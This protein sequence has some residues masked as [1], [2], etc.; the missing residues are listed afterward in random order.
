M[1]PTTTKLLSGN[2]AIAWGAYDYGVQ[3]AVAYP[4]TPSTEILE[5]MARFDDL[6]AEWAPNEK[7]A[8][9][10][11]IGASLGGVRALASMKHV[12]LNVAADP[13]FTASYIGVNGGLV[14][15]S[16]DDPGMHSSQNEQDN[17][18]YALAA[19][20]PMLEPADSQEAYEFIGQALEISEKYDT[21]VLLRVTTR[22]S[23]SKGVVE[24]SATRI[25]HL[26][27][28]G[29]VK[30]PPKYVM[31]PNYA[32][33]RHD[34]VEQRLV[35]LHAL[36][37]TTP[38]NRIEWGRREVGIVTSGVAYQYAR[39]AR[40]RASFLK[41][42]LTFPLPENL[43]WEFAEGVK[44]VFVVEELDPYLEDQIK[45]LGIPA[46]GKERFPICG[47][48]SPE[49]VKQ[50][51]SARK[52]K[53]AAVTTE[54]PP[55][56]PALCPG[57]PHSATFYTIKKLKL[58]VMG[59]I[60]CYT[61]SVAPPLET[62]DS[63]LCMGAS[64]GM[65]H[66]MDKA[67]G[68]DPES[69]CVAVLGDSTFLHS[70]VSSLMNIAYNRGNSTTVILDNRT[71]AMTG[72][73]EH[74]ATGRTLQGE[75]TPEVDFEALGKALGIDSVRTVDPY[76]MKGL[77]KVLKEE[78]EAPRSSLII[79]RRD[80]LLLKR[81]ERKTAKVVDPDKCVGCNLCLL[82][83]CPALSQTPDGKAQIDSVICNGCPICQQICKLDA[84]SDL[85]YD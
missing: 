11:A 79:A 56:P 58:N 76:E 54:I 10:V 27:E 52:R 14:V 36:S 65:A 64:I 1:E 19:K 35:R 22:V 32:R 16:A 12:G 37:E 73:Q 50:G 4:G 75:E 69:R 21:P 82:T 77:E 17:R 81:G 15:I 30:D 74:A 43:I 78:V 38:L 63:T 18:H 2:E 41:L 25:R 29:F 55:R 48:L 72:F 83:G 3:V 44:K 71:T 5:N 39:E 24:R 45:A 66:G 68:P 31:V 33:K 84:I 47:E 23:H 28:A 59:D 26:R 85:S 67:L 57:C 46:I 70:G 34:Y 42:G 60:G 9:E 80:C 49:I 13:F 6:Y 40:P 51:L 7:V 53:K 20:V 8:L 61:L 62:M